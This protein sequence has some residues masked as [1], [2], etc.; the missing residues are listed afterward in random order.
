MPSSRHVSGTGRKTGRGLGMAPSLLRVTP[1]QAD[2]FLA[3]DERRTH[4]S[5]SSVSLMRS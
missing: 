1:T 3:S 2:V 5:S 4:E